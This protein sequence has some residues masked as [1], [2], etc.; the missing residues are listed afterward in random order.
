V[1]AVHYIR[2]GGAVPAVQGGLWTS[3]NRRRY[4][5]GRPRWR[6]QRRSDESACRPDAAPHDELH[7]AD[8]IE[9]QTV[10]HVPRRRPPSTRR[11]R[12]PGRRAGARVPPADAH[13]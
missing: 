1:W 4:G 2:P 10:S 9:Y 6:T 3:R 11:S 12:P 7:Q 8:G 5:V 13:A